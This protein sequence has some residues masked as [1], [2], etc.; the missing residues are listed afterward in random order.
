MTS[1]LHVKS[2]M[3]SEHEGKFNVMAENE[4]DSISH[5]TEIFGKFL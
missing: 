2:V 3:L 5:A 1:I 4:V